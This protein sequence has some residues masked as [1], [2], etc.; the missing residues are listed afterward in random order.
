MPFLQVC[1]ARAHLLL[2]GAG[3][4]HRPEAFPRHGKRLQ[5][6]Q[7]SSAKRCGSVLCAEVRRELARAMGTGEALHRDRRGV[8]V[9]KVSDGLAATARAMTSGALSCASSAALKQLLGR[10]K[11]SDMALTGSRSCRSAENSLRESP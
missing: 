11:C 8:W 3:R 6:I 9:S 2:T 7:P 4:T 1:G 5:G 10:K